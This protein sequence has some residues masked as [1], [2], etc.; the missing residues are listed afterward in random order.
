MQRP[1]P[2]AQ[3][4]KLPD[5]YDPS[6]ENYRAQDTYDYFHDPANP[7]SD[8]FAQWRGYHWSFF[9][10]YCDRCLILKLTCD[11]VAGQGCTTCLVSGGVS[12]EKTEDEPQPSGSGTQPSGSGTQP[13]GSGTQPSGSGVQPSGNPE[14]GDQSGDRDQ[15]EWPRGRAPPTVDKHGNPVTECTNCRHYNHY[16]QCDANPNVPP[17]LGCSWC[18]RKDRPCRWNG[19]LLAPRPDGLQ[20]PLACDECTHDPTIG[21]LP[22]SWREKNRPTDAYS[23]CRQCKN[24]RIDKACTHGGDSHTTLHTSDNTHYTI[25]Q[26][27]PPNG[28]RPHYQ[29]EKQANPVP[30]FV[31]ARSRSA[32]PRRPQEPGAQLGRPQTAGHRY[33]CVGCSMR[34]RN[35]KARKY[36]CDMVPGVRGCD[37]CALQ[38]LICVFENQ[39][40]PAKFNHRTN[41]R[42]A[43]SR[44]EGC[45][46]GGM[47]DR[48]RPCDQCVLRNQPCVDGASK[49]RGLFYRGVPGDDMPLYYRRHGYGPFGVNDPPIPNDDA[50]MPNGY[51]LLWRP[52]QVGSF[53]QPAVPYVPNVPNVPNA[54]DVPNP[55]PGLGPGPGP[56]LDPS[57]GPA[58]G[59]SPSP[60]V[61]PSPSPGPAPVQAPSPQASTPQWQPGSASPPGQGPPVQNPVPRLFASLSPLA[62]ADP[63]PGTLSA[64][65]G[66]PAGSMGSPPY[67][68][69][70]PPSGGDD[71][72]NNEIEINNQLSW[73][74]VTTI[75]LLSDEEAGNIPA[76]QDIQRFGET[77][78]TAQALVRNERL[79]ID[80]RAI[81]LRLRAEIAN[82]GYDSQVNRAIRTHLQVR[83]AALQ[84]PVQ[85]EV[86]VQIEP[87]AFYDATL[88]VLNP[89]GAPIRRV[90]EIPHRCPP[91]PGPI[92]AVLNITGPPPNINTSL[93]YPPGDPLFVD[94]AGLVRPLPEDSHPRPTPVLANIPFQRIVRDGR[95]NGSG[96]CAVTVNHNQF[97]GHI[98][99]KV[100]TGVCEDLTHTDPFPICDDC[101]ETGRNTFRPFVSMLSFRTDGEP[102]L[103]LPAG[104]ER[105]CYGHAS[106]IRRPY[107]R[108]VT[109][110]PPPHDRVRVRHEAP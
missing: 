11:Y 18:K 26:H 81:R 86:E 34:V 103:G 78:N 50:A 6:S 55:D 76:G 93:A 2:P 30:D 4:G 109:R 15:P 98:C 32:S 102:R 74:Q 42:Q 72:R 31:P 92:R 56:A 57:P 23:R 67:G 20:H 88:H 104:N 106:G 90:T 99:G 49:T 40:L 27:L 28:Q 71:E 36:E 95:I 91:S 22:C 87:G 97:F 10:N 9:S 65:P 5:Y 51:H 83:F 94:A 100:T 33:Q 7:R 68:I 41:Y 82:G 80:L 14:G 13:S 59:P 96:S 61:F 45:K 58:L 8:L 46:Y 85:D 63:Y 52:Q 53:V 29:Q 107:R 84:Q 70:S 108:W 47:C 60:F 64:G 54:P 21:I 44:C 69:P 66:A 77:W 89:R 16:T 105:R 48:K 75:P 3:L 110:K 37:T 43:F 73:E 38:G 35:Y 25:T 62:E 17:G 12:C 79:F 39:A 101:E 1:D 19:K 24:V